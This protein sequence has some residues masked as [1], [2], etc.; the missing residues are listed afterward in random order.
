MMHSRCFLVLRF[1][2]TRNSSRNSLQW[3]S[4]DISKLKIK[5]RKISKND[6]KRESNLDCQSLNKVSNRKSKIIKK[7]T[8]KN[9]KFQ[10]RSKKIGKNLK[11]Q[12]KLRKLGR[13]NKKMMKVKI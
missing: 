2:T 9:H 5:L 7:T 6:M 13:N 4:E 11:T 12:M 1:L 10:R 8:Q 3:R